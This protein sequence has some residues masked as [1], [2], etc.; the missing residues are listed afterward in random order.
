MVNP[1][2]FEKNIK[3][4]LEGPDADLVGKFNKKLPYTKDG[5]PDVDEMVDKEYYVG[6][7][8]LLYRADKST[9]PPTLL[10]PGDEGFSDSKKKKK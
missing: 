5:A 4:L 9:E 3:K 6:E 1:Y 7:D 10:E 2:G 8:G